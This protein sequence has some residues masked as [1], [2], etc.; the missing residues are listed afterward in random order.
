[1]ATQVLAIVEELPKVRPTRQMFEVLLM[2]A[3][4]A[5][6]N[7]VVRTL[8]RRV[9]E[10]GVQPTEIMYQVCVFVRV[11]VRACVCLCGF[12]GLCVRACVRACV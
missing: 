9:H 8:W 12:G 1:M 3:S 6:R 4:Q 2:M 7:T 10:L 11:C 5:D